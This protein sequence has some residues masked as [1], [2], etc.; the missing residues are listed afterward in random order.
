[1][2]TPS[3]I[4]KTELLWKHFKSKVAAKPTTQ[5]RN[6]ITVAHQ[7]IARKVAHEYA[8][9]C[10]VSYEDLEQ[11]A[12]LGMIKAVEKFDPTKGV[13]F[14][15]F[16]TSYVR[17]EILHHLRDSGSNVKVPRRSRETVGKANRAA[18]EWYVAK[19]VEPTEPE[20]AAQLGI[21]VE[22]LRSV[23]EAVAHQHACSFNDDYDEIPAP[24]TFALNDEQHQGLEQTWSK[25]K[26]RISQLHESER[27]L[28]QQA[29]CRNANAKGLE[30]V[31]KRYNVAPAVLKG[32]LERVLIR[33][34][35]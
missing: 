29:F 5:L 21:T 16:A 19:G 23:R 14:S 10:R 24:E 15:S 7:N 22:K 27:D 12:T 17:G 4:N 2:T 25:L 28:L 31:A 8:A 13:A 18:R 35:Q 20:L 32:K 6:Q 1:M 33:I 9:R 30:A 3:K 34:A 11:I 26:G